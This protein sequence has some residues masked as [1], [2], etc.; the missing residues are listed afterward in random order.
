M[1]KLIGESIK[2]FS[3][4]YSLAFFFD[5]SIVLNYITGPRVKYKMQETV[6]SA[7]ENEAMNTITGSARWERRFSSHKSCLD[8]TAASRAEN[9]QPRS[10]S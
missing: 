8:A 3:R 5:T 4:L 9:V 1:E 10:N 6:G 7:K 2:G